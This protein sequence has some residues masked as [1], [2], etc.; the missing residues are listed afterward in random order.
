MNGKHGQLGLIV[1]LLMGFMVVTILVTLIPG[2]VSVIDTAQNSEG[3]NCNGYTD[4]L[5]ASLSYNATIG[6]KSSI[7]CLAMKLYL[8][9]LI[10]AVLVGLVI[11]ILYDKGTQQQSYNPYG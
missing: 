2:F 7:G 8:P 11:K 10:L 9:Y 4:T 3:L 1:G 5:D 6:T